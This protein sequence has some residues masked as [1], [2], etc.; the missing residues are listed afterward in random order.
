MFELILRKKNSSS[1]IIQRKIID[2]YLPLVFLLSR[3]SLQK[4]FSF[5]LIQKAVIS[6]QFPTE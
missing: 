2:F 5:L 6:L 1:L 3:E 4:F